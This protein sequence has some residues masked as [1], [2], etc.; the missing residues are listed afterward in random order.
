MW[1]TGKSPCITIKKETLEKIKSIKEDSKF[2]NALFDELISDDTFKTYFKIEEEASSKRKVQKNQFRLGVHF[3]V[4]K[5][6]NYYLLLSLAFLIII[7]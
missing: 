3:S 2:V 5:G 7:D 4:M 6:S 1:F